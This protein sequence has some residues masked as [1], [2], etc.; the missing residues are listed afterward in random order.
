LAFPTNIDGLSEDT[1]LSKCFDMADRLKSR[2]AGL[3]E[4]S[5]E[6]K[7]PLEMKV[8]FLHRPVRNFLE[9]P[10]IWQLQLALPGHAFDP[11]DCLAKSYL[12][13]LKM[14]RSSILN[15]ISEMTLRDPS[16]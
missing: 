14:G 10:E 16:A 12:L 11:N 8:D 4:V 6:S 9:I 13:Q 15:P 3:L 5:G 7:N 2:C 1:L